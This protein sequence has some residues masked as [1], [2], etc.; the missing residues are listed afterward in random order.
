MTMLEC[1]E[2]AVVLGASIGGLLA[3]RVL[4]DFY[5]NVTVV[6]RDTLPDAAVTR[7][8]VPQGS[9]PHLPTARGAQILDE[10]FPGFLDELVAG[11][12][13]VWNDGDLSRLSV[14][15]GGHRFLAAGTIPD[16]Q[17]IVT[18]YVSRPFLEY[19]V[20]QRVHAMANVAILDGH[21]AVRLTSTRDQHRVTGGG[22]PRVATP[23]PWLQM[24]T[25]S[26]FPPTGT[27]GR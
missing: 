4:A 8:G 16:P 20:R 10:L 27:H 7:R 19:S 17:S 24:S 6:E 12:A 22:A 14:S 26:T 18:Y 25:G 13:R 11:G 5:S 21:D 3:A 9:L 23:S 1:G 2:T 15:F